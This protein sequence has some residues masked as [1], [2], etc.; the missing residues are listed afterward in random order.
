MSSAVVGTGWGPYLGLGIGLAVLIGLVASKRKLALLGYQ[1]L[2]VLGL[3]PGLRYHRWVVQ[4]QAGWGPSAAGRGAGVEAFARSSLW[5][6][7]VLLLGAL[8]LAAWPARWARL[9]A[10]LLPMAVFLT[11]G[12]AMV[13]ARPGAA[14]G[15]GVADN[16]SLIWLFLESLAAT[17]VL[18]AW[19]WGME[20]ADRRGALLGSDPGHRGR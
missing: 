10:A 15:P 6:M 12:L 20:G 8:W 7:Y 13:P 1:G 4:T 19:A 2:L 18:L 3:L 14:M 5:G 11:V 9:V 17:A 16:M